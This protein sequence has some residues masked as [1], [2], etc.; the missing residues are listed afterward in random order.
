MTT[1]S[2][3]EPRVPATVS[4]QPSERRV[5]LL[6]ST[7]S[8]GTQTLD[9]IGHLNALHERGQWPTRYRVVGLAAGGNGELVARQAAEFSVREV[10]LARGQAPAG[11]AWR[12]GDGAAERL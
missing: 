7:G 4:A 8:I 6:G 11:T 2:S 1:R 3:V 9:V 5:I 12:T 10:A